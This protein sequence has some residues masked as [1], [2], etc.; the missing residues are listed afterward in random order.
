PL[1]SYGG[2][3]TGA[4]IVNPLMVQMDRFL[5][6]AMVSTVAVAYYTT[7]YELVTKFWFIANAMLGV[8]FPAFATSFV[9]DRERTAVLFGRG[10]K[11]AFLTLFPLVLGSISLAP[12]I[13]AIWLGADFAR[14]SAPVM[15]WLAL[16]VLL[17]GLAQVPSA[18]L[19]GVGRP[20]LTAKL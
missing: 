17:N 1:L 16:G 8:G 10:V 18:L 5:V 12:E 11:Y 4:N 15:R 3:M 13:L 19:Q 6:G 14:E 9:Q 7:P 20:D 2:W